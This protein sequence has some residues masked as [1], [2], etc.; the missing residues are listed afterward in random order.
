MRSRLFP[1]LLLALVGAAGADDDNPNADPVS[2]AVTGGGM[3][4]LAG[5][6]D[7]TVTPEAFI[8][9]D[10]PLALGK[11]A[12]GRVYARLG[13]T[14]LPGETVDLTD[15]ATF[16]AAEV[17]FGAY[18]ILG[19]LKVGDQVIT[20]AAVGEWGFSSVL[21]GTPDPLQRLIRHYGGGVRLDERSSGASLTFLYG[22]DEAAGPRG[23]GQW[24][25]YGQ[26]PV[27]GTDGIVL[28]VGEATLAA[29]P[30]EAL[31][32]CPSE[33]RSCA[34]PSAIPPA[35]ELLPQRDM[36]RLGVTVDLKRVLDKLRRKS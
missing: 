22:R 12:I 32:S 18:R 11:T 35:E 25:V 23:W 4:N 17:D 8:E 30:K 36:L 24:I 29:G 28:L 16:R 10:G 14:S 2:M 21:P 27:M 33:A 13:I 34:T 6:A 26:V 20:T 7:A 3:V 19:H 15:V 1:L 31:A 9:V 5:D